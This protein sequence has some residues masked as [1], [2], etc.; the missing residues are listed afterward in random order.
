M[1][2]LSANAFIPA[3]I[4]EHAIFLRS[5]YRDPRTVGAILPS[6]SAL[7]EAIVRD[8]GSRH[9]PVLEL[10]SGTGAFTRR[11]VAQGIAPR[12]LHLVELDSGFAKRLRRTFPGAQVYECDAR[13]LA[14]PDD[15]SGDIGATVSG[16]PL[17]NMSA[18]AKMALLQCVFAQMRPGAPLYAFT[19][20]WG[21]PISR[22]LLDRLGLRAECTESVLRN[23]P[24]ARVWKITR[25]APCPRP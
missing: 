14:L 8:I 22:R 1:F 21:C 23:L 3:F 18:K 9:A 20:G 4:T 12:E 10:G 25:R 5:W 17:L 11:L 2:S 19:Y 16:L 15:V 7:A 6:G 24:P 13:R